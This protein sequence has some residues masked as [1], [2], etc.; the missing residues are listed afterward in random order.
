MLL[1]SSHGLPELVQAANRST[2]GSKNQG[3]QWVRLAV[4]QSFLML[5]HLM[6]TAGAGRNELALKEGWA[7][8]SLVL[9]WALSMEAAES[10]V[11]Q[12]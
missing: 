5:K 10:V 8:Q 11:S 2:H 4:K 1:I 12:I 3:W 6:D 9:V 7:L